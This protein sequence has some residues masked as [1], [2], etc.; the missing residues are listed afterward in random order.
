MHYFSL[1]LMSIFSIFGCAP[2]T[3]DNVQSVPASAFAKMIEAD[4]NIV[5]LDVRTAGE[6]AMG[7]I[8][9]SLNIDVMSSQ[10][11]AKAQAAIDSSK[12]VALYCQSGNRSKQAVR[13]LDKLGYKVIELSTGFLGWQREGL[14]I[15]R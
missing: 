2:A 9:G 12:T 1:I 8:P 11:Q 5:R 7:H 13:I 15:E 3:S 6:H 4:A 10:F 14:P